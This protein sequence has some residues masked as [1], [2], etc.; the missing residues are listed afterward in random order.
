MA[1]KKKQ[2]TAE[3]Q[4][5]LM[6]GAD[7]LIEAFFEEWPQVEDW[8]P[9][10]VLATRLES[11]LPRGYAEHYTPVWYKQFGICVV[12]V[13]WKWAQA[14]PPPLAS[15]AEEL[16]AR[17][18]VEEAKGIL[19]QKRQR[20]REEQATREALQTFLSGSVN[21]RGMRSLFASPDQASEGE[22]SG[23]VDQPPVFEDW[24]RPFSKSSKH[25]VHPY[26]FE[27][28]REATVGQAYK[29]HLS[30]WE[31]AM[32]GAGIVVLLDEIFDDF[33]LMKS[34]EPEEIAVSRL[35]WHLPR[36]YLPRYTWRFVKQFVVCI[37]IV[38]WKLAQAKP[39]VLSSVAEELATHA[40]IEAAQDYA[41]L[42]QDAEEEEYEPL[43]TV[44]LIDDLREMLLEDTDC[45][46][47]FDDQYDGIDQTPTGQVIGMTP[48]SFRDWLKPFTHDPARMAH[49]YVV[50]E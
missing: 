30:P 1:V 8:N 42:E 49:P 38:G 13:A 46:L 19:Q 28:Q 2:L 45:L 32:L 9:E 50:S 23:E 6:A 16:A 15:V 34:Q 41:E 10:S 22:R 26:A 39:Q 18:I 11:Y 7:A 17:A 3:E 24:V 4:A 12:V 31:R 47:L 20:E 43:V 27:G 40:V 35:G 25:V 48:M 5:V 29:Q 44:S 33:L 37:I 14:T 21:E 36:R